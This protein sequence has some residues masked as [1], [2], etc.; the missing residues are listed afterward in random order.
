MGL[1]KPLYD[2]LS[3][4]PA[5][6]RNLITDVPG[7]RVGHCTLNRTGVKTGVTAILPHTGNTFREKLPAAVHVIN[8]FGKSAGL[9]QIEELGTLESPIV[10]T[11]TFGVGTALTAVVK[12]MLAQNPDIGDTTGTINAV[13]MECNDGEVNDIRALAVEEQHVLQALG[14]AGETFDEGCVG[15]GTGMCC[16]DLKGG[17][18]S[19]S[20]V[21]TIDGQPFTLG[22]LVLSNF[23]FMRDLTVY[24]YR[25]GRLLGAAA[26]Q[27]QLEEQGSIITIL[28][29]DIPLSDRQLRRLCKRAGVGVTRTG[30]FVGNGSGEI[31]VGFSTANRLEHYNEADLLTLRGMSEN[32]IDNLFRA[33]VSAV[34]EA[35]LSSLVH[36]VTTIDRNGDPRICFADA[37]KELPPDPQLQAMIDRLGL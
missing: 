6:P 2:N 10:L 18:G 1:S 27:K 34:E 25:V 37:V 28:A 13:V 26:K 30:A 22:A 5:G 31:V 17:I 4:C 33:T 7:V 3:D 35:V 12:S 21:V 19:A 9:V 14:N 36:A 23:G 20:R 8:G 29:T 16:Y 15:A 24:G 32:N 11:N